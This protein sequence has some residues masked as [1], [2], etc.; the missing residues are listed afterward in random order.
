MLNDLGIR[1][2]TPAFIPKGQRQL[3]AEEANSSRLVTK[4][5]CEKSVNVLNY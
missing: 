5:T 4:V 1:M 3:S 2:E